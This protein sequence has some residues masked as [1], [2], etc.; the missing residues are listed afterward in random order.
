MPFCPDCRYEFTEDVTTCPDC[1]AKLV[2]ALP[3][4]VE[5]GE[6]KWV[7]LGKVSSIIDAE[8]LKEALGNHEIQVIIESDIF[9]SALIAHGTQSAGTFAKVFVPEEYLDAAKE[10]FD[11]ISGD[12]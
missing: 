12:N 1:G 5:P 3:P 10:I 11:T 9:N 4:D 7:L 2:K 8:M 6:V